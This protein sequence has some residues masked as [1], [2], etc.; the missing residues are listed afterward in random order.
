MW[1]LHL[2]YSICLHVYVIGCLSVFLSLCLSF[3]LSVCLFVSLSFYPC[4]YFLASSERSH[5]NFILFHK[6]FSVYLFCQSIY[7]FFSFYV[8]MSV[9]SFFA[10]SSRSHQNFILFHHSLCLSLYLSVCLFICLSLSVFLSLRFFCCFIIFALS[11]DENNILYSS[12]VR[13]SRPGFQHPLPPYIQNKITRST[14][15]N[16]IFHIFKT[17][18]ANIK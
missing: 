7:L 1:F 12:R 8:C 10:S 15:E 16:I 13:I 4:V 5:Q 3:C 11:K 9:C 18:Y 17:V 14:K 2:C 6:C